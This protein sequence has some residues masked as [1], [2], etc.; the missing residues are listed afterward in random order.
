M[1]FALH[2]QYNPT[3]KKQFCASKYG[4]C[5]NEMFTWGYEKVSPYTTKSKLFNCLYIAGNFQLHMEVFVSIK[6]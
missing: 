3:K 4:K 2:N 5:K 6:S 1:T